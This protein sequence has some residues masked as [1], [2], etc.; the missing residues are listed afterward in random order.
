MCTASN[1]RTTNASSKPVFA[2][3]DL[4]FYTAATTA[5]ATLCTVCV[6]AWFSL[7]FSITA[8]AL[9]IKSASSNMH[10]HNTFSAQYRATTTTAAA[11][12]TGNLPQTRKPYC[13]TSTFGVHPRLG[14]IQV[15][16]EY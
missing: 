15:V 9:Y 7:L 6:L 12:T 4:S 8:A 1:I 10:I 2:A 3:V 13:V 14:S 16:L 5:A 11:A